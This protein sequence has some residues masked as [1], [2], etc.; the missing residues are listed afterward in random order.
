[1]TFPAYAR[2]QD[3]R[4]SLQRAFLATLRYLSLVTIPAGIG[5]A[6][7]ARPLVLTLYGT[8]WQP[9]IPVLQALAIA[10]ALR[11]LSSHAGDIYKATGR[12]DILTK[13]GLV[14]AVILIPALIL[15]ARFGIAGVAIAQTLVTAASTVL[16]LFIAGRILSIS[17]SAMMEEV[18]PAAL[19]AG[20]M[21]VSL[22]GLLAV[23]SD[24]THDIG[25]VIAIGV[26]VSVYA[27]CAWRMNPSVVKQVRTI[28]ATSFGL[29][30]APTTRARRY[31][32]HDRYWIPLD[33]PHAVRFYTEHLF[34]P[35]SR[36]E[37]LRGALALYVD[38]V[39]DAPLVQALDKTISA[40]GVATDPMVR[41]L[42]PEAVAIRTMLTT[43]RQGRTFARRQSQ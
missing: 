15:G 32:R 12:P 17:W 13:V 43:I 1:V 18:K 19:S 23:T 14:R 36:Q 27:L 28:V 31:G 5:I 30:S 40:L 3:D 6:V 16:S 35:H 24:W 29:G 21:L 9:S 38:A 33:H 42:G 8:T 2:F 7:L 37:L 26:G 39:D 25:L 41:D 22:A 10:A 11:S 34:V 20:V 4:P